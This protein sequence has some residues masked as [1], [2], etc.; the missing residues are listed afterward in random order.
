MPVDESLVDDY[1]TR[2]TAWADDDG[3]LHGAG[4]GGVLQQSR[5]HDASTLQRLTMQE[6]RESL[7]PQTLDGIREAEDIP[8]DAVTAS[9]DGVMVALRA[10]EGGR[11]EACWREAACGTAS[12]HDADGERLKT[13]Y[14][15]RMPEGRKHTLKAQLANEVEQAETSRYRDQRRRRCRQLDLPQGS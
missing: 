7:G 15:G 8:Q 5:R 14:L 11:S 12:F 9:L 13:V 6:R 10:G 1:L 3:P 4:S 2:P